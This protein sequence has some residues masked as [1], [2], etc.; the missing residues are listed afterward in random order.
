MKRITNMM[1]ALGFAT[2]AWAQTD[3]SSQY[4]QNPS[5]EQ[6]NISVLSKDNTRGAYTVGISLTGWTVTGS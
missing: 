2:A 5:F 6:N 3:V 1:L 4:L